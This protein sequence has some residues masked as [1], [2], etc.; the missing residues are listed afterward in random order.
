MNRQHNEQA[1]LGVTRSLLDNEESISSEINN[2]LKR[3]DAQSIALTTRRQGGLLQLS[4]MSANV[5]EV[6]FPTW[7][8]SLQLNRKTIVFQIWRGGNRGSLYV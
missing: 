8:F 3:I 2:A 4:S 5:I 7:H 6:A 1:E